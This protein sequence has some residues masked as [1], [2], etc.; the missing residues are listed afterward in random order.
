M[1]YKIRL[2]LRNVRGSRLF[3]FDH[4]QFDED[5][6]NDDRECKDENR[7]EQFEFTRFFRF[8]SVFALF[9]V[10]GTEQGFRRDFAGERDRITLRSFRCVSGSRVG[11]FGAEKQKLIADSPSFSMASSEISVPLTLVPLVLPRSR[12]FHK[13]PSKVSFA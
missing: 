12:S 9:A 1:K 10:P 6:K 4:V 2:R 3:R 8:V 13:I 7:I 5:R 11:E